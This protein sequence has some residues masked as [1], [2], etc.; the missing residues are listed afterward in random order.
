MALRDMEYDHPRLEE[1]E[2]VLFVGRNLTEGMPL[3]MRSFLHLTEREKS[4]LVRLAHLFKR[5]ANAHVT[6]QSSAAIGRP[7]K[8][9]D[10]GNH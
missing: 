3:T 10:G 7:F 9:G 6:R 4:N 5:P 2:I 8:S 1:R